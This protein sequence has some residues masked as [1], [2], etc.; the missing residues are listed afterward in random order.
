MKINALISSVLLSLAAMAAG[1]DT[2]A[3]IDKSGVFRIGYDP[4]AAPL[5]FNDAGGQ[6]AGYSVDMCRRIGVAIKEHLGRDELKI[7]FVPMGAD[8]RIDA[9]TS[10]KADI[11]CGAS[12]ITLGRMEKVDFTIKTFVT[13]GSVI[14]LRS[15]PV[16][17]MSDLGGRRVAVVRGTTTIDALK[18]YLEES[19]VDATVVEVASRNEANRQLMDGTVD[20][21]ASDQVVLIGQILSSEDPKQ[22]VIT[23]DLFSFEPYAFMIAR[24]EP[25]F[26]LI[27]NRALASLYRSGQF[28]TVYDRWIG[29]AGI[30]PPGILVAMYKMEGLPE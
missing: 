21:Y 19:F 23:E 15:N 27:A 25:E 18:T 2:L 30:K 20:A 4:T 12:T 8:E 28:K 16:N 26:R 24:G 10:G 6:A 13:G 1:A 3:R 9:I 7:E 5:S 29:R 14:S 22:F 11:E 17:R